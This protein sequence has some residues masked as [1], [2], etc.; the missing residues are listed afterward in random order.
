[1]IEDGATRQYVPN[2]QQIC[3]NLIIPL[4]EVA[5]AV[6]VGR[7][8]AGLHVVALD[9]RVKSTVDSIEWPNTYLF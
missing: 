9:W 2:L 8:A 5:R 7:L 4:Q 1:M 6:N 3:S